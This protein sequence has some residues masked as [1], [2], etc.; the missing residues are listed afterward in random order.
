MSRDK[1]LISDP[2]HGSVVIG[3]CQLDPDAQGPGYSKY[4]EDTVAVNNGVVP[5]DITKIQPTITVY[6]WIRVG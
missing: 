2:E 5:N 6:R 4:R 1:V 3:G